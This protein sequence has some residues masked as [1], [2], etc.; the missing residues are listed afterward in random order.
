M[1]LR[2]IAIPCT[3]AILRMA[4]RA[5]SVGAVSQLP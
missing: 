4:G 2:G 1:L 5:V 3:E